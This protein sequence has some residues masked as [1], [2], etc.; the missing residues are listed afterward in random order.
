MEGLVEI[1]ALGALHAGRAP[2]LAGALGDQALRVAEQA[3]ELLVA[4]QRYPHPTGMA[5]IDED[6]RAAGLE[7]DVGGQPADVP[8]IAHRDQR[9]HG[10]LPVLGGVQGTEQR[11]R[12]QRATQPVRQ[13]VPEGLG[14][15]VLLRQL[16]GDDVEGLL[17]GDRDPLEGDHLLGHG[18]LAEVELDARDRPLLAYPLDVDLGLLF[19][20]R[21]PVAVESGDD[22]PPPGDVELLDLVGAAEMEIDG[23]G[24]DRRE[25]P[26]RLDQA[27]HLPGVALDHG[28]RARRRRAQGD[29]GRDELAARRHPPAAGDTQLSGP[30]QPLGALP[31]CRAEDLVVGLGQRQLVGGRDEMAGG[32]LLAVVVEDRGLDRPA[33]ELVGVAAEELVEGVLAGD[34]DG[35]AAVSA[36]GPPPHLP[37]AGDRARKGDADRRIELA[38]VDAELEGVGGDDGEQ[39]AGGQPRLDLAPLLGGVAAPRASP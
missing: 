32:D 18:D 14:E 26:L 8:A 22:R 31:P 10:D 38:D 29:L 30:D 35:E 37:Q 15:E 17:L 27:E 39:L 36:P 7:V 2:E 16:Q 12:G 23:P 5:V 28:H 3:L 13:H 20:A 9:Q 4:A 33:E 19:R 24:M 25:G 34:I 11:V 1:A 21:V 6:R